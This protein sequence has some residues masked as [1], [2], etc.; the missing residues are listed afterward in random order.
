MINEK[1]IY[2]LIHK[3]IKDDCQTGI[4]INSFNNFLT[5][6]IQTIINND[7]EIDIKGEKTRYIIKMYDVHINKPSVVNNNRSVT[8]IMPNECRLRD[9]TYNSLVSI[10]ILEQLFDFEGKLVEEKIHNK[11]PICHIPMMLGSHKCNLCN[12][13]K[14]QK[15]QKSR[16]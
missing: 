6:G 13:T 1:N 7:N 8:K 15:I 11:V 3:Y 2:K 9:V 10:N 12:L 16:Y 5:S 4:Q 14:S